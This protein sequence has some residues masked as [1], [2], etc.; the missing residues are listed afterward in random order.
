MKKDDVYIRKW[1]RKV[2]AVSLLGGKCSR[3]GNSNIL[4][5]DFH[6][7]KNKSFDIYAIISSR[8]SKIEKEVKKCVLL[9]KNCHGELHDAETNPKTVCKKI[10][11]KFLEIKN[12]FS[13]QKCGYDKSYSCLDFHHRDSEDKDFSLGNAYKFLTTLS[14]KIGKELEKCDVICRNCH[15][16]E[17]FDQKRFNKF[18]DEIYRKSEDMDEYKQFNR[19]DIVAL[20]KKGLTNVE[21][22]KKMGLASSTVSTVLSIMGVDRVRI[23]LPEKTKK[24]LRCGEE[25]IAVGQYK[26]KKG[27]YCDVCILKHEIKKK[28]KFNMSK[29]DLAILLSTKNY[30]QIGRELSLSS[31]TIKWW[32]KR[33][34]L[35]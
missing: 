13:C 11:Y 26:I 5:L 9:C 16:S 32:A 22:C 29:E 24:C 6:H 2:R 7:N 1:S 4:C 14:D 28:T 10:K 31:N 27:N 34:G 20:N 8:W 12:V 35:K 25:F 21:I 15:I 33:Y 18:K 17:H 3:C 23:T 30:S 19:N